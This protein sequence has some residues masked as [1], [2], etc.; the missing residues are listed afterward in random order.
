MIDV[1]RL[2]KQYPDLV[3]GPTIALRGA[4]FQAYGGEV[5]AVLGANGAG[6]TTLLRILSTVLQPSSGTAEIDGWDVVAAPGEARRRLGFVSTGAGVYDRM[7]ALES[8]EFFGRLAGLA[9]AELR[10]RTERVFQQ[11]QMDELRDV[12]A[13]RMSTGMRQKVAIAQAIVHD[14]PVVIFDEA[15]SGLDV[16]ATRSL[17]E[18]VRSLR[19][20]GKCV[21]FSSHVMSE[22][23]KLADRAVIFDRGRLLA[24]GPLDE[25]RDRY[26]ESD[27]EEL[28]FRLIQDSTAACSA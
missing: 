1:R 5:L 26:A 23:E 13:G 15:T 12:L 24:E 27:L 17:L 7:T 10:E 11:L 22:V 20:A 18:T 25:L 28:F 6:K 8:V 21:L 9:G 16:V 2:S 19:A 3:H 14:P 4:S